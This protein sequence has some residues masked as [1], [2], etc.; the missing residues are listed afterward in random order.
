MVQQPPP[1]PG[2]FQAPPPPP[3]MPPMGP[4]R[5][6]MSFDTSSLPLYDMIIGGI[7][8]LFWIFLA[9]GWYKVDFGYFGYG[10]TSLGGTHSAMGILALIISI[11]LFSFAGLVIAN[12]YLNFLPWEMPVGMIYLGATGAVTLF[13][14]L[15][16]VV[17]GSG[18]GFVKVSW[19]IF[20][21]IVLAAAS[22]V[23]AFLKFQEEGR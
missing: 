10:S 3:G 19:G 6:Q 7:Q 12:H 2:G 9:I 1:P 16:L 13:T 4:G 21:C 17:K 14:L 20:V 22:V 11:V 23:V 15:G 18:G 5:P 8:I